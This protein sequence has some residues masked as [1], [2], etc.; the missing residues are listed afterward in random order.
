M[1]CFAFLFTCC[2]EKAKARTMYL[3]RFLGYNVIVIAVA[4]CLMG[5]LEKITFLQVAGLG[6]LLPSSETFP[7][8]IFR[9]CPYEFF[10]KRFSSLKRRKRY[11][12]LNF[13][14]RSVHHVCRLFPT[15]RENK[16]AQRVHGFRRWGERQLIIPGRRYLICDNVN[17]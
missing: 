5:Y 3:H 1:G 11:R 2:S 12:S 16:T 17:H 14:R 15:L 8:N 13:G 6:M 7:V 4:T 9:L 10:S